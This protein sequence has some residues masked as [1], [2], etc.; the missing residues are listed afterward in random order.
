MWRASTWAQPGP[1]V[2]HPARIALL[3]LVPVTAHAYRAG[4]NA[5]RRSGG[6]RVAGSNPVSPTTHR[7][8][9]TPDQ[10]GFYSAAGRHRP[11]RALGSW[12]QIGGPPGSSK[13]LRR[14]GQLGG[15]EVTARHGRV[16]VARHPLQQVQLNACVGHPRQ[17]RVTQTVTYEPGSPRTCSARHACRILRHG[18]GAAQQPL[19]S[20]RAH[21]RDRFNS[22]GPSDEVLRPVRGVAAH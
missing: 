1:V 22:H 11:V 15:R 17:R 9:I 16:L 18:S 7:S 2:T 19:P 13:R 3:G 12:A 20:P 8:I 6:Q 4:L 5:P 14:R 10:R 21:R